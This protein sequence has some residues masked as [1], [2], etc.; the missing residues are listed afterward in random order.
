[1]TYI[2]VCFRL[3]CRL[4]HPLTR[5][6]CDSNLSYHAD[7]GL[8]G[9]R[10]MDYALI[11]ILLAGR[12]ATARRDFLLPLLRFTGFMGGAPVA[13][14]PPCLVFRLFSFQ[15]HTAPSVLGLP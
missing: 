5:P 15:P 10:E 13:P 4:R 14:S 7:Y 11:L 3:L 8:L 6:R 1:M 9:L 2:R 12:F